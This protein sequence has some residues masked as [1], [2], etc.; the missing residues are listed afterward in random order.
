MSLDCPLKPLQFAVLCRLVDQLE[1]HGVI[2]QITGGL[3][4]N[5]HGSDW[6]LH[7]IDLDVGMVD[8]PLVAELFAPMVTFPLGRYVDDEFDLQLLRL[9]IGGVGVDISQAEEGYAVTPQ[10]CR[11]MITDLD[12]RTKANFWGLEL[13]VQPLEDV[14][15]YKTTLGRSA[16]LA[17]LWVLAREQAIDLPAL[18]LA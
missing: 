4:G 3:A 10:G 12:R 2:Y 13:Y 7:D 18:A 6:P 15:A 11:A 8:M 9:D 16:D 1:L 14:I 5:I 17:D